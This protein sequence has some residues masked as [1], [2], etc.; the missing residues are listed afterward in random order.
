MAALDIGWDDGEFSGLTTEL[1]RAGLDD[2]AEG[3]GV[4][5]KNEGDAIGALKGDGVISANTIC[6]CSRMRRWNR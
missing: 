2:A 4:V 5:A 6:Q 3:E 1:L